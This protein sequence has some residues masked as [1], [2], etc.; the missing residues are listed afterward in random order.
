MEGS[1]FNMRMGKGGEMGRVSAGFSRISVS[2]FFGRK[3]VSDV[4]RSDLFNYPEL[5]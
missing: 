1:P 2:W 5:K 4:I 3:L